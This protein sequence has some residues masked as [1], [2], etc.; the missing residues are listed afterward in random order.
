MFHGFTLRAIYK[1][2]PNEPRY[3]YM[4]TQQNLVDLLLLRVENIVSTLLCFKNPVAK[5]LLELRLRL[6]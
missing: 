5:F 3:S 4:K 2:N 6:M 1:W